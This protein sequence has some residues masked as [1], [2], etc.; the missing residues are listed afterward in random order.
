M[1]PWLGLHASTAG[2]ACSIPG[3]GTNIPHAVQLGQKK[4]MCDINLFSIFSLSTW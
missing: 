1:V 4:K 3:Q 2:A